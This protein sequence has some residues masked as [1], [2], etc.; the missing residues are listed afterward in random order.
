MLYTLPFYK[1]NNA[2]TRN[3]YRLSRKAIK[4]AFCF[5]ESFEKVVEILSESASSLKNS[6]MDMLIASHKSCK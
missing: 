4:R 6:C 3:V 2:E 1:T 5:G